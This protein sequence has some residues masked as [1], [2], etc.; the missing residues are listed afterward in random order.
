LAPKSLI[1]LAKQP[2]FGFRM[3]TVSRLLTFASSTMI[4]HRCAKGARRTFVIGSSG[5]CLPTWS[6]GTRSRSHFSRSIT[7]HLGGETQCSGRRCSSLY[8]SARTSGS[9]LRFAPPTLALIESVCPKCGGARAESRPSGPAPRPQITL[10][11][12]D[13]GDPPTIEFIA[14][15]SAATTRSFPLTHYAAFQGQGRGWLGFA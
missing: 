9:R 15:G 2:K 10:E 7:S 1:G 4:C 14:Q 3:G 13:E 5:A 8:S 12:R 11:V 6:R